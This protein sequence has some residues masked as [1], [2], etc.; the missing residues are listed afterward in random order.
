M[1]HFNSP[2]QMLENVVTPD[3][4]HSVGITL[5]RQ[6]EVE[7]LGKLKLVL[8][9]R[10][11]K[12]V[13]FLLSAEEKHDAALLSDY[14][15]RDAVQRWIEEHC[16]QLPD[17]LRVEAMLLRSEILITAGVLQASFGEIG[18]P[19]WPSWSDRPEGRAA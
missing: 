2:I 1:G 9:R 14:A 15:S 13:W 5:P 6:S 3:L 17:I 11:T 12:A 7:L 19:D 4:L 18:V 10:V 8:S 16:P